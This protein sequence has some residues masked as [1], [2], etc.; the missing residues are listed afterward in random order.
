MHLWQLFQ[1]FTQSASFLEHQR[2]M[3]STKGKDN[4]RSL[5]ALKNIPY[6]NQIR[7]L[8]DPVPASTIFPA[9]KKIYKWLESHQ[10]INKFKYLDN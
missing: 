9:F 5:F 10:I 1:F 2:L 7:N 4:A 3:R 8:L 6:D